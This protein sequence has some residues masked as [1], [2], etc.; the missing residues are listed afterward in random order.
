MNRPNIKEITPK[1][2]TSFING[3]WID[4]N[5]NAKKIPII[6]PA[7]EQTVSVLYE[8][9]ANEV[10]KAA[11]TAKKTFE[12]GAWSKASVEDRK[13]VL[14]SIKDLI[15]ENKEEIAELEVTNTGAPI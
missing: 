13:S 4:P 7:D 8:A 11:E 14:L 9:D 3:N 12:S 10:K 2:V 6:H 15:L 1:K 5:E